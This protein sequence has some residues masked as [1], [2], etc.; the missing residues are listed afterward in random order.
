[1]NRYIIRK[2]FKESLFDS[3]GLWMIVASAIVLSGLCFLVT[4][5]KEGSVLAQ[6]DILQKAMGKVCKV[7]VFFTFF[8]RHVF[9]KNGIQCLGIV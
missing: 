4:N 8:R 5:I 7:P 3:R 6:N 2:E 1:M 9:D